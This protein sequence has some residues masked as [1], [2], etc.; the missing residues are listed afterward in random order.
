MKKFY[1]L[2][3]GLILCLGSSSL[4]AQN[5]TYT[6]AMDSLLIHLDKS[7]QTSP[8]LYDRVFSFSDLDTAVKDT[9]SSEYFIQSWSELYRADNYPDFLSPD[10]LKSAA[11]SSAKLNRVEFGL[12]NLK[13]NNLNF[14]DQNNPNIDISDGFFRN[15]PGKNPFIEKSL[16]MVAPLYS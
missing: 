11:K 9:I 3:I 14:G 5:R 12:L 15:V 8:I 6:E 7:Q 4:I 10:E 1:L 2:L 16:T 13:Y